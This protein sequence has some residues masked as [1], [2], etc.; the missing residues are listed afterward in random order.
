MY[1][2][3]YPSHKQGI[4]GVGKAGFHFCHLQTQCIQAK[5]VNTRPS[6]AHVSCRQGWRFREGE[7]IQLDC[8]W[9][10]SFFRFLGFLKGGLG[11][12]QDDLCDATQVSVSVGRGAERLQNQCWR[13]IEAGRRKRT[14]CLSGVACPCAPRC[15]ASDCRPPP[16]SPRASDG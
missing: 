15:E 5:E 10:M 14:V 4:L 12:I 8:E 2:Y 1:L 6:F 13:W 9:D 11:C 7:L 16:L 3:M